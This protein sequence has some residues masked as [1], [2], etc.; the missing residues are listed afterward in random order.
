LRRY[1]FR[2][3]IKR[4]VQVNKLVQLPFVILRG[5]AEGWFVTT[6]RSIITTTKAYLEAYS[7]GTPHSKQEVH[8]EK[9]LA[10]NGCKYAREEGA[11]SLRWWG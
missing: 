8:Q 5:E 10:S 9:K 1:S 2:K 6:S 3:P 7:K 4:Q 11:D